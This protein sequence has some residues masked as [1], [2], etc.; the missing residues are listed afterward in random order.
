MSKN[1]KQT[2]CSITWHVLKGSESEN[3]TINEDYAT[4]CLIIIIS[5]MHH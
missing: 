3:S 2:K 1:E 5:G 4:I